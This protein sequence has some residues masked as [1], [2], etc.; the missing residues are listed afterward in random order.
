MELRHD[1]QA[2]TGLLLLLEVLPAVG[3][4]GLLLPAVRT[5]LVGR[6][7]LGGLGLALL[8]NNSWVEEQ[9]AIEEKESAAIV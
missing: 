9:L 4:Q 2:E 7:C 1:G 6:S 5:G 3:Q 8:V